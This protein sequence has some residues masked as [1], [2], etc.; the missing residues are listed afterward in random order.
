MTDARRLVAHRQLAAAR[1]P[2]SSRTRSSNPFCGLVLRCPP[3]RHRG[4]PHATSPT[5][6]PGGDI[7][8][9]VTCTGRPPS[10]G[11]ALAIF[12]FHFEQAKRSA[13]RL[14]AFLVASVPRSVFSFKGRI[15][16]I[17]VFILSAR[18]VPPSRPAGVSAFAHRR[19]RPTPAVRAL[20]A[21]LLPTGRPTVPCV[22]KPSSRG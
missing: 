19:Q 6:G 22:S 17:M 8:R 1:P 2:H 13:R 20:R 9:H 18:H 7:L 11:R 12:S 14:I 21:A 15:V 10:A 5:R 16:C 3:D 4:L